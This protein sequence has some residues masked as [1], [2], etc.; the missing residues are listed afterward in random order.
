MDT[1]PGDTRPTAWILTE[2][3][4]APVRIWGLTPAERLRRGVVAAGVP[5]DRVRVGPAAD[6]MKAAGCL[7]LFRADYVFDQ[8]LV[9]AMVAAEN[10]VL[11]VTGAGDCVAVAAHADPARVPDAVRLLCGRGTPPG[12]EPAAG[13]RLVGPQELARAYVPALRRVD[14]PF[15]LPVGSAQ[16]PAVERRIFDASYKGVT[17]LVTK[18]V[19][20]APARWVTRR[21]A[22]RGV[23]PNAVTVGS[24]ALAVLTGVLFAS[25]WFGLGLAAGW[26]MTFL[27][28]VDGKL[29]RVTLTS[30]RLG[31][32]LDHG[33]DLLHPPLWY[34]A[35]AMGLAPDAV[36]RGP[37]LTITV[38]GYVIG[39]LIEGLFLLTCKTQIHCWRPVDS[40]FRTIT[41]RRNPNMILLT[42]GVFAGRP[43][44]GLVAVAVWTAASVAF[45]T[46][47]LGQGLVARWRGRPVE[48]W[49]ATSA[50]CEPAD[51]R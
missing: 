2:P 47:R 13:L 49:L 39:R 46:V 31:D 3:G 35:W 14:P 27:D 30:S 10:T 26:I 9:H 34:L 17:D 1:A 36:W 8:R 4:A 16:L 23:H 22:E 18:W 25:G 40:W 45:H 50:A 24:W 37:A 21:L 5:A 43:D 28:T 32:K 20:P 29:A 38:A 11:G 42:G 48:S 7:V 15:L 6:A 33:L 41:A 19:W 51:Q 12:S 44:L